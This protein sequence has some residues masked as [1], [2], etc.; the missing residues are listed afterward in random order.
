ML[1]VQWK[2]EGLSDLLPSHWFEADGIRPFLTHDFLGPKG[3]RYTV[4]CS[5]NVRGNLADLDYRGDHAWHN[6]SI[7]DLGVMRLIFADTSRRAVREVQWRDAE[8]AAEF[9]TIDVECHERTMPFRESGAFDPLNT[10]DS[11]TTAE[12]VIALR[13][14]Q[15]AFRGALM[16]A[17]EGRCAITGCEIREVLEAAHISPYLGEHTNHVSNGLLLRADV[18]T[19][20]DCGLINVDRDYRITAPTHICAAYHLPESITVPIDP[21]CHPNREALSRRAVTAARRHNSSR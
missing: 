11:R 2:E 12:R 1:V 10:Q 17:Y 20:F 4:R 9:K 14:G 13:R 6:R 7:F 8:E 3:G 21:S 18:H 15:T 5:L 19:L 16:K